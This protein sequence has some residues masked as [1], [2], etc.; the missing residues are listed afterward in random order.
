MKLNHI[1]NVEQRRAYEYLKDAMG[2]SDLVPSYLGLAI[3]KVL[4]GFTEPLKS[5]TEEFIDL[6]FDPQKWMK[7]GVFSSF[8]IQAGPY[9]PI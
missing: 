4:L 9:A 3:R 6:R 8:S 5:H 7:Q 2:E 1:S